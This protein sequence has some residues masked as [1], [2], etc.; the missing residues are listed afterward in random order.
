M[1]GQAHFRRDDQPGA[2]WLV[3]EGEIDLGVAGAFIEAITRLI[4][5]AEWPVVV[6]LASVTFFNSTGLNVLEAAGKDAA[7]RGCRMIIRPSSVVLGVLELTGLDGRFELLRE[8][9]V[10]A[11]SRALWKKHVQNAWRP[12]TVDVSPGEDHLDRSAR[13]GDTARPW[14][15]SAMTVA[16]R[17]RI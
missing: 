12:A 6:D 7:D 3:V 17:M 9:A 14:G 4:H 13:A 5:D 8:P 11:H 10:A 16:S 2:D 15:C 1:D